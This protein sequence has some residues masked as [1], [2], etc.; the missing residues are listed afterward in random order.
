V[1][2]PSTTSAAASTAASTVE[3]VLEIL[4]GDADQRPTPTWSDALVVEHSHERDRY[5]RLVLEAPAIAATAQPGQFVMLTPTRGHD[6][7]PVLPRPMAVFDSDVGRCTITVLYGV[8]GAGTR[9]LSTFRPGE[10]ITTVGPLGRPFDLEGEPRSVLLL[11]RGIGTCSLSLLGANSVGRGARVTAVTSGRYGAAVIGADFY[12]HHGVD[13]LSVNDADGSSDVDVLAAVLHARLDVA[14]PQLV[15][16]CGSHRLTALASRLGERWSADV[17][18]SVEAHMACGLGY[19]HGC[20]TGE[21]TAE[22]ESPL[23][24]KDG[25]VFRCTTG[26][27]A[28]E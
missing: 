25:P 5:W 18:V 22:A 20:A 21:R 2:A 17:Q 19:C 1:T 24:C 15:A 6:S 4:S 10:R 13:V 9:H 8:V 23:V 3:P 28:D 12:R 11:G 14:P 27:P 16:V 7:W 26:R